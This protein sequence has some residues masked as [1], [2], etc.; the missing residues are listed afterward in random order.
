VAPADDPV[1]AARGLVGSAY[2]FG[3][4][5]RGGFDC[6][7]LTRYVLQAHGVD[8]PRTTEEQARAGHWVPLDELQPGDL[9]FFREGANPPHHV[10]I[11][12]SRPGEPLRMIHASTSSGV[13]ETDVLGSAYWLRRL[14]F[15]RRVLPDPRPGVRHGGGAR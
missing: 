13:V 9:V 8:L 12:S 10:G 7:G 5:S 15:G 2:R 1:A 6:S 14:G 3:G 4:A 11:V